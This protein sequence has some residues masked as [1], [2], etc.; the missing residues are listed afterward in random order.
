MERNELVHYKKLLRC[1]SCLPKRILALH[2]LDNISEFVLHGLCNKDCFNL[3]K[4]AY[5][6]DNPDFD[7]IKGVA[8]FSKDEGDLEW[9]NIWEDPESFTLFTK[10]LP[11]NKRV[12]TF[13]TNSIKRK[14]NNTYDNLIKNIADNIG[15]DKPSYCLWDMKHFNHGILVY[16]KVDNENL[17]LFDEH[18]IDSLHLLSFCP[19]VM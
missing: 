12:R 3:Y 13:G 16:E 4:A 11:F 6:V 10:S 19:I 15:F 18:F 2:S 5:F 8:G 7:F 9:D 17:A 1:L 14:N